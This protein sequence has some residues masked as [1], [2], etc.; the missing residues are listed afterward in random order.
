MPELPEVQTLVNDLID[1]DLIGK[2]IERA[3]VFWPRTIAE[4]SPN[5]FC[6]RLK[7][8]KFTRIHRRGKYLVFEVDNGHTMLLHLR[9]S[10]RLHLVSAKPPPKQT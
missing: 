5:V 4:P 1:A 3:R 2:T 7:G 10:G 6:R 8:Q 9:M